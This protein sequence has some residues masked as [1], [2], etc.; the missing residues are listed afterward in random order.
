[1][2]WICY[3]TTLTPENTFIL[4]LSSLKW[5]QNIYFLLLLVQQQDVHVSCTLCTYKWRRHRLFPDTTSIWFSN[6]LSR[7]M[8]IC[9]WLLICVFGLLNHLRS[10][11]DC[12]KNSKTAINANHEHMK[13]VFPMIYYHE[14]QRPFLRHLCLRWI[15]SVYSPNKCF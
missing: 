13:S 14:A 15:H 10:Y 8:A 9:V 3:M 11:V 5:E 4:K 7:A 2:S 6:F 12:L 1:M